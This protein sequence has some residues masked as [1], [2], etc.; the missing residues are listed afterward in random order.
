M[1]PEIQSYRGN[2]V[3]EQGFKRIARQNRSVFMPH[4]PFFAVVGG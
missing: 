1:S 4:N 2:A 3:I